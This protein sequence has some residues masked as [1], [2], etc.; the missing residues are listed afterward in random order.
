MAKRKKVSSRQIPLLDVYHLQGATPEEICESEQ[1]RDFLYTETPQA[2]QE[3][4]RT[5]KQVATIFQIHGKDVTLEIEKEDWSG[6]IDQCITYQSGKE[7]Y[8]LCSE[9]RDI[10]SKI[11]KSKKE[12][13]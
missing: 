10:K 2:I 4:L 12:L 8:E 5:R 13:I 9:L 7:Q 11:T 1:F 3:A 6:A